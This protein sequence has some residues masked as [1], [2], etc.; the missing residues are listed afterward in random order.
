M[1]RPSRLR[2]FRKLRNPASLHVPGELEAYLDLKHD[3]VEA[4]NKVKYLEI[5]LTEVLVSSVNL[6]R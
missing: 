4:R 1:L 3:L 5:K 2:T 6:E